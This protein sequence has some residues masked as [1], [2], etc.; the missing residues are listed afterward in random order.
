METKIEAPNEVR[1][2]RLAG[3]IEVL[4]ER[5]DAK[6]HER[7]MLMLEMLEEGHTQADVARAVSLSRARVA[8]WLSTRSA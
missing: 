6:R 8:K 1:A 5:L 4:A 2:A 7:N 3:Q